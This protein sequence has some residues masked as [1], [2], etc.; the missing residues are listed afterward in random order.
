MDDDV[1]ENYINNGIT[2]KPSKNPT[3]KAAPEPKE[4]N[5]SDSSISIDS[6]SDSDS[7]SDISY[8]SD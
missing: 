1:I 5:Q 6:E 2:E 4:D 3:N 8:G 7:D